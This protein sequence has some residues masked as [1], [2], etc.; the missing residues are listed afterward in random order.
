MRSLTSSIEARLR[1]EGVVAIILGGGR[2]E[3]LH[4]LT[5]RRAKPAVPLL[6]RYRL[7]D[8]PLS[9]C[10]HSEINRIFV[11]TQFNSVSLHQHVISSY[12]FDDSCGGFANIL[13]AQQTHES[14]EW[15]QG[16]ADAVRQQMRQTMRTEA[17]QYLIV[18]GD[19][20]YHMD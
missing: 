11:L 8:I 2:G 3:R 10:I 20:L 13:P 19:H 16:T 1:R 18:S 14:R 9:N 4:S 7:V 12:R 5:A 17:S 15:Y 6:G